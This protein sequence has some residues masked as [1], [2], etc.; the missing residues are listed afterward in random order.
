MAA[1]RGWLLLP[2]GFVGFVALERFDQPGADFRAG[3]EQRLRIGVVDLPVFPCV[4]D[5]ILKHSPQLDRVVPG[6]VDRG[7]S[8]LYWLRSVMIIRLRF[9]LVRTICSPCCGLLG[10]SFPCSLNGCGGAGSAIAQLGRR[11]T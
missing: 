1:T 2:G 3:F 5:D 9:H 4:R 10:S 7:S 11:R 8:S 6:G